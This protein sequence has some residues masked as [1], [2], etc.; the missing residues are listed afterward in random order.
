MR[1]TE[2]KQR[3]EEL[4]LH[5]CSDREIVD[6]IDNNSYPIQ[7]MKINPRQ[8]FFRATVLGENERIQDIGRKRL[9]YRP[10][11]DSNNYQRASIPGHTMFYGIMPNCEE[12]NYCE[13]GIA[14][15][16]F[17]VSS[18][19][20][21]KTRKTEWHVHV[22][23]EWV[24][25]ETITLLVIADPFLNNKSARLNDCS[26]GFRTFVQERYSP[27]IANEELEFQK[28]IF[29]Q[30]STPFDEECKYK[31]PALFAN[32]FLEEAKKKEIKIDGLVWQSAINI[33]DKLNDALCVA[34]LPETIDRSFKAP[35]YFLYMKEF[36]SDEINRFEKK[37]LMDSME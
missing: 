7:L 31:I 5:N 15:A 1:K 19:F 32:Q 21:D 2:I 8:P 28:F 9:S 36:K 18:I 3:L 23:S 35:N 13:L 14:A 25:K 37:E 24:S 22:V 30:F 20:R 27:S 4:D 6:L 11:V 26:I 17:E 12:K 10:A 16:L 33:D 29:N 34:I